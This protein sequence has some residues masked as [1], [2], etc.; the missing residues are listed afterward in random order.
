[1]RDTA[2]LL[3]KSP[4]GMSQ[5]LQLGEEMKVCPSL[6]ECRT[7]SIAYNHFKGKE[8]GVTSIND[9][10]GFEQ[11]SFLQK[12]IETNWDRTP[13][14]NE[15]ELYRRGKFDTG[16]IGEIDLL[17]QHKT[18]PIWLVIE[19]KKDQSSDETIGQL[20]R[21]MGWVKQELAKDDEEV[22]GLIVSKSADEQLLYA[23]LCISSISLQYYDFENDELKL[24]SVDVKRE[25]LLMPFYSMRPEEQARFIAEAKRFSTGLSIR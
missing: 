3:A 17:A 4:A 7:F 10:S 20:F 14:G 15:W 24:R 25:L 22:R 2:N 12:Y 9:E 16:R 1:M 5:K 6:Q 19:L 23:L 11:E 8:R 13:L 18:E 21:Y